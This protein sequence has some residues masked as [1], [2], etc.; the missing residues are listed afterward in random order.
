MMIH[1]DCLT[2]TRFDYL[3]QNRPIQIAAVVQQPAVIRELDDVVT[4]AVLLS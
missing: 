4:V 1:N 2:A 3:S